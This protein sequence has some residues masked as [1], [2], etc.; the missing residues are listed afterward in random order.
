MRTLLLI[1]IP[2]LLFAET[3]SLKAHPLYQKTVVVGVEIDSDWPPYEFRRPSDKTKMVG[4]NVDVLEKIFEPYEITIEYRF[5]PWK[6]CLLE[7]TTGDKIQMIFPTSLNDER[8]TKFLYTEPAYAISPA[9]FYLKEE[10][11]DGLPITTP[12]EL[13]DKGVICG[14]IGYN[15][16]NFGLNNGLI[17][18]GAKETAALFEKLRE[19]R[20]KT[21][22]ARYEIVAGAK[23]I[24]KDYLKDDIGYNLIPGVSSELFHYLIS[25]NHPLSGPIQDVINEGLLKRKENGELEKILQSYIEKVE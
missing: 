25:R 5:L 22:V 8:R 20:C 10:F 6:R 18:R 19:Q 1:L 17:E 3:D 11:P 2:L 15:Y 13:Y 4:Y 23:L 12:D 24:N 21:V 9:Y 16:T 14:K 7:L